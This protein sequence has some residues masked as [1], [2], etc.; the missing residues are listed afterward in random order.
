MLIKIRLL[1]LSISI[2]MEVAFASP[3]AKP[4]KLALIIAVGRYPAASGWERLSSQ[5][6]IRILKNALLK[7]GFA[8]GDIAVV[9]DEAATRQG[10]LEAIQ[11]QLVAKAKPGDIAI[12]HFS[13]HGQ[14]AADAD[15]DEVDGYDEALVPFDSPKRYQSGIY[16]GENLIRDEELGAALRE[17][18]A[19]I[20]KE[21]HLLTLIDACHSGT[22]TRG[23]SK[24]RGTNVRMASPDYLAA[25]PDRFG[26]DAPLA[27]DS[28]DDLERLAPMVALFS[29]SPNQLSYEHVDDNG[30]GY[31]ILSYTFSKVFG[32]ANEG[33]SYRSLFDQIRLHVSVLSPRQT[34]QAEGPLDGAVLGGQITGSPRYFLPSEWVDGQTP[35][36]NVGTLAGLHDGTLVA[37]YPLSVQDTAGVLPLAFGK[38]ANA[39]LFD[40]DVELEKSIAKQDRA[41][42]IY[43]QAQ[44]Y[45]NLS[46]SLRLEVASGDLL[47]A[48]RQIATDCPAIHF[49][50]NNP[51]MVL[52]ELPAEGKLRLLTKDDFELGS[53]K[54]PEN[55]NYRGLLRQV[56]QQVVAFAQ[57]KFLRPMEVQDSRLGLSLEFLL[58]N[59]QPAIGNRFKLGEELR[60]RIRNTGS[61]P[62]YFNV[63]DIQPDNQLNVIVPAGKPA[64]DYYL[65]PGGQ[66]D[67]P[68]LVVVSEPIGTE[69]LKLIATEQ[70][71]DLS[72]IVATRGV[73]ATGQHSLE[74][75][76]RKTYLRDGSRGG[77]TGN[78][79]GGGVAVGSVV[80]EI[81]E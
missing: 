78:L 74:V 27:D 10:I 21:G 14:Q 7:Q 33:T 43:I 48:L 41:C 56:Q 60:L 16:E 5:N 19:K 37:I 11:T 50:E 34:P 45:G 1:I 2:S 75:L 77:E 64:V 54:I 44:N 52:Q 66:Y 62:C 59:G 57:A 22:A 17:V 42:R 30:E 69:V 71:L 3:L 28:P 61:A 76:L 35:R 81:G 39:S 32:S 4:G 24:A 9:Q 46:A 38:I 49:T 68:E 40:C 8:E 72:N 13:G 51:E 80:V 6:D 73:S 47:A 29:A 20:G 36:L 63:L 15:A 18:R 67:Y 12:F 25:H 53:F 70:P 79:P 26:E 65:A 58:P 23:L 31:G 55:E